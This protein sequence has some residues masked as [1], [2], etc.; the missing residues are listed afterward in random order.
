MYRSAAE[1]WALE[2]KLV[3]S[4]SINSELRSWLDNVIVPILVQHFLEEVK[5]K[6]GIASAPEI[7]LDSLLKTE[8]TSE[9]HS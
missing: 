3:R 7:G 2:G 4:G 6:N 8:E 5:R 9:D 1:F